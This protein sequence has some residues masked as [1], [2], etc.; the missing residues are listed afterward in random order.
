MPK[1]PDVTVRLVGKDGNAFSIMGTVAKALRKSGHKEAVDEF[2]KQAMS[3]NYDNLL[4]TCMEYVE[5]E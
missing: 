3:G 2:M 1:F 5:V 4:R